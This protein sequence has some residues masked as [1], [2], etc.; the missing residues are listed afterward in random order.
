M[1]LDSWQGRNWDPSLGDTSFFSFCS[2]LTASS[3]STETFSLSKPAT[4]S[5][6]IGYAKYIKQNIANQC[7]PEEQEECFGTSNSTQYQSVALN[8][9]WRSWIYQVCT[10]WGYFQVAAPQGTPSLL[11]RL[12][13]VEYASKICRQA[14]PPGIHNSMSTTRCVGGVTK[15]VVGVPTSPNVTRVNQIGDFDLTAT[16]IAFIE[17]VQ[18]RFSYINMTHH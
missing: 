2:N 17:C 8:Q 9:T 5:G 3:N 16:R 6:A 13:D 14:F 7:P 4:W 12:L 18:L 15:A 11:S 1:P 10:E